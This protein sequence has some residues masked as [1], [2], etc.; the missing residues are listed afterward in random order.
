MSIIYVGHIFSSRN[1]AYLP[2]GIGN[3]NKMILV[4]RFRITTQSLEGPEDM[5][6]REIS[7]HQSSFDLAL[8]IC[9]SDLQEWY[10]YSQLM[11]ILRNPFHLALDIQAYY[12]QKCNIF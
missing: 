4:L 9:V 11:G 7:Y 8:L 3:M 5:G 6:K 10:G 2:L 12:M 1:T